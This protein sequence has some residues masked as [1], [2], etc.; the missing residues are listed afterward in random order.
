[1]ENLGL[2]GFTGAGAN[3][4]FSAL[5]GQAAPSEYRGRGRYS[6]RPRRSSRT[7]RGHV[8]VE[9]RRAC[10]FRAR[11]PR[12]SAG[13]QTRG[14]TGREGARRRTELRRDPGRAPWV[15]RWRC[16]GRPGR[17]S[18]R[19]R[20]RVR[21]GRSR[22]R[23]ATPQPPTRAAKSGDKDIAAEVG[24]LERAYAALSD[25]QPLARAT[26]EPGDLA[27]LAPVF[28]LTTKPTLVV[29]NTGEKAD[30][31]AANVIGGA[32]A[33]PIDIEAE[34]AAC[35]PE[36]RAD[37]R[38]MYGVAASALDTVAQAA[39]HLL[40]RRTFLTTGED[41]SRG[42]DVPGRRQS[43]RMRRCD[44]QRPA[45]RIHPSRGHRLARPACD[46][47][48]VEGP[49]GGQ[50]ARR[51][52]GL[53]S[54]R[55]RRAR[56]P[57]QRL[58]PA[59]VLMPWLVRGDDV[60]ASAEVAV[61]RQIAPPWPDRPRQHRRGARVTAVPTGA[62]VRHAIPDRR[63]VL[64]PVRVRVARQPDAA[65]SH[66]AVCGPCVF[67]DRGERRRVRP[68]AYRPR[69]HRRSPRLTSMPSPSAQ[70][71][72]VA[73]GRTVG[74]ALGV[75][76]SDRQ[77]PQPVHRRPVTGHALIPGTRTVGV[78]DARRV[79]PAV[80]ASI[81]L[82]TIAPNTALGP[83][84]KRAPRRGVDDRTGGAL[85]DGTI[86]PTQSGAR[87]RE[88][89]LRDDADLLRQRRAAHRARVPDRRGATRSPGGVGCGATTSCSSPAPTSTA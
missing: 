71:H 35:A 34:I 31:T 53:R 39:Y 43:T 5:T 40:G 89:V 42:M 70:R 46:R 29:L 36:D 77:C 23:R 75:R 28:C 37:M 20:A 76:C 38:E 1:M 66:L 63:R 4:L 24:T 61:T 57:V 50:T 15:R 52:Q 65:R 74:D 82:S 33:V 12:T 14:G 32:I 59:D 67:R 60:L 8:G 44:P 7:A 54:P 17:R 9:E 62:L 18:R 2:V 45:T 83:T 78:S 85:A 27:R 86:G 56:D 21:H 51:R 26:L 88:S 6:D 68:L 47:F 19:P 10:R 49:S 25:G 11:T 81:V 13:P 48:M 69:R 55:R 58:T 22:Q 79:G 41:E 87:S 72:D 30:D 73:S 84:S 3:R 80:V 16:R 64:R